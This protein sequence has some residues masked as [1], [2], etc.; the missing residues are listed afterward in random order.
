MSCFSTMPLNRTKLKDTIIKLNA[1][2]K[3]IWMIELGAIYPLEPKGSPLV[4]PQGV[5]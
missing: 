3:I 2:E 1:Y 5:L 4:L